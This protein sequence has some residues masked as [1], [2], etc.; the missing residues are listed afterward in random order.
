M[1]R[2]GVVHEGHAARDCLVGGLLGDADATDAAAIDLNVADAAVLHY[3]PRHPDV[4]RAFTAGEFEWAGLVGKGELGV[5]RALDE[6]LL[7]PERAAFAQGGQGLRGARHF[8]HP[9]RAGIHQKHPVW[10][11]SLARGLQ[12]LAVGRD[13]SAAKGTPAKL[14]RATA[15]GLRRTR[16]LQRGLRRVT[17]E[18]RVIGRLRA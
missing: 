13:G 18:H 16:L 5:K 4:V 11:D 14:R 9:D 3:L 15:G 10:T 17:E 12:L 7:E 1:G 8:V 6:G 2:E